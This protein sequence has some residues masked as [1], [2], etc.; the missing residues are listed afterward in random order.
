MQ[1]LD[2]KSLDKLNQRILNHS[3]R[4]LGNSSNLID[5]SSNDYIGFSKNHNIYNNGLQLLEN[6]NLKQNG[7][8]GSR[9]ISGNHDLYEFTENYIANF[10]SVEK[11]LIFNSG[12]NANI[13]L[14]ASIC[15]RNDIILY[16]EFCHASIREGILLS[17]AKSYKFKHNSITDLT[18][19]L[20]KIDIEASIYIITESVFSMDGDSPDLNELISISK[21]YKARIIL[22]EA[23]AIGVF[24]KHGCGLISEENSED[25]FARVITFGKAIGCHGAAVLGS[26]ELIEYLI[27]F[28][29]SF[30]YTTGLSPHSVATIYAAYQELEAT[31]EIE[32]LKNNIALFNTEKEKH[33][34][35][36]LFLDSNSAIQCVIVKGNSEVKQASKVLQ[37]KGYNVKAILS[38]TVPKN[39][40]RLRFCLHSYNTQEDISNVF[41]L[42]K[43]IL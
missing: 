40:E 37:Q 21:Q 12:Y 11:A 17:N 30:I 34:L 35:K 4:Q 19:R 29:K 9:L 7:A 22:D 6:Q 38:P 27:N 16:D 33:Q 8:T 24:G 14:I 43:T 13:G 42:L 26:K 23:H 3:L 39:T 1:K 10:H 2:K 28:S 5:F 31:I 41:Q 32:K 36:H 20:S 25:I 18:E 15:Q